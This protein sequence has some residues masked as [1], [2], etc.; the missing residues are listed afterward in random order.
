MTIKQRLNTDKVLAMKEKRKDDLTTIRMI[1]TAIEVCEKDPKILHELNEEEIIEVIQKF[2]KNTKDERDEFEKAG[3][4][5]RVETLQAS[6]DLSTNYLPKQLTYEELQEIVFEVISGLEES[7][8]NIGN[9]MKII[10]PIVKGKIENKLVSQAVK[11]R[12][13]K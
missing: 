7:S 5:D 10:Q 2:I 13:A 8:K 9:A 6:I 12:L 11:E 4:T 3:R 1:L